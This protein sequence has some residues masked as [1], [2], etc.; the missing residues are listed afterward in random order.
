MALVSISLCHNLFFG[1]VMMIANVR[2][3]SSSSRWTRTHTNSVHI[4]TFSIVSGAFCSSYRCDTLCYGTPARWQ[5][6][7]WTT[8]N[9]RLNCRTCNFPMAGS[10]SHGWK[11]VRISNHTG[12]NARLVAKRFNCFLNNKEEMT[13]ENWLAMLMFPPFERTLHPSVNHEKYKL[14]IY[15]N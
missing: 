13:K 3:P 8:P 10:N 9:L 7:Y 6:R 11:S 5:A 15:V 12:A 14:K 4:R 2:A 1:R